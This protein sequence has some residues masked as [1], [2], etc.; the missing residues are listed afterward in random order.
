MRRE[1]LEEQGEVIE[2]VGRR[3]RVSLPK[4]LAVCPVKGVRVVI[5]DRVRTR[6]GVVEEVLERDTV[7]MRSSKAGV[8]EICANATALLCV[9]A[10]FDPPFRPGLVDRVLAAAEAAGMQG[11]LVLNKC[12]LGMPEPILER[13]ALYE[14]LG[15]P[16]FMLSATQKKG[17]ETLQ[18]F[19]KKHTTV[20]IGHSGVGKS[21]LFNA[22]IPG[23]SRPVGELDEEGRGRH[24]TTGGMLLELPGGGRL[25]D[26]PGVRE[27]GV[28]HI[29]KIELRNCFPEL[30]SLRCRYADCLH[31]GD[32]GCIV[33]DAEI[34]PLRLDSYRK[35]LEED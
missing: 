13:L 30:S 31:N 19:L 24:T 32:Q 34:D 8:H 1:R 25:L 6:D 21:S 3:V 22:L 35:L 23:I 27:F 4:G 11:G 18:E 9:C 7:L 12:D 5:G 15:Y 14:D 2:I 20:L 29:P 28:E 33:E 10:T 16:I 17:M 26:I